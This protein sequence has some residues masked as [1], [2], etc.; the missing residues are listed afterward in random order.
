MS[1]TER[2]LELS[3]SLCLELMALRVDSSAHVYI[4]CQAGADRSPCRYPHVATVEQ[5]PSLADPTR[6]VYY[7][8]FPAAGMFQ[9]T[10]DIGLVTPL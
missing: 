1:V 4:T 3:H 10:P 9:G 6:P 2:C 7:S 8:L 5:F